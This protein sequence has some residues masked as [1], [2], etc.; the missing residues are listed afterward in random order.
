MVF[1][2]ANDVMLTLVYKG[3]TYHRESAYINC[4][5][6]KSGVLR[7]LAWILRNICNKIKEHF[8]RVL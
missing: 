1:A 2:I 3:I 7:D 5:P 4:R 6:G 8:S